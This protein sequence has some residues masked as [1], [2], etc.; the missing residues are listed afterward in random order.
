MSE[1]GAPDGTGINSRTL[2]SISRFA[3]ELIA[4]TTG[5]HY[6]LGDPCPDYLQWLGG[7]GRALDSEIAKLLAVGQAVDSCS[8]P[9]RAESFGGSAEKAED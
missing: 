1:T 9:I 4:V 6:R 2:V 3:G 8:S 7:Q 5:T